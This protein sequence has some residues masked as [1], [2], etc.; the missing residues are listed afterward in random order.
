MEKRSLMIHQQKAVTYLQENRK[1]GY[2]GALFMEMRL[3]KTLTMI[4]FLESE[5]EFKKAPI[6]IL[7]PNSVK[8]T[9]GFELEEEG[10]IDY[11][12]VQGTRKQKEEDLQYEYRYVI[13]NY[14]SAERLEL[15]LYTWGAIVADES[16]YMANPKANISKYLLRNFSLTSYRYILCGNPAPESALQYFN[17][18]MFYYGSFM[19]CNNYWSYREHYFN[20]DYSGYK[21]YIKP[22][23]KTKIYKE[24]RREAFTLTRE[25]AGVGS[26]KFYQKLKVPT[27]KKQMK[28]YYQMKENFEADGIS[29]KYAPVK[30]MFM[31]KIAGGS[32]LKMDSWHSREK[33]KLLLE[34]VKFEYPNQKI[35]V[36]FKYLH[37]IREVSRYLTY[38]DVPALTIFGEDPIEERKR[39]REIFFKDPSLQICCMTIKSMRTGIDMSIADTAIYY[40]NEF[41]WD[42]R[43]QSEDRIISPKQKKPKMFID[44][45]SDKTVDFDIVDLLRGKKINSR[46]FMSALYEKILERK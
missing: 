19:S 36:W 18:M 31:H 17:Q 8:Y 16:I 14:E 3:G 42:L 29:T 35:L 45:C 44:L 30:V 10:I 40:S 27:T 41:S 26:K 11:L 25:E 9:W 39:K 21:W 1:K 6:L 12:V 7:C 37:E 34:L 13:C 2:G 15:H 43:S 4:R 20:K 22:K 33:M 5:P 28:A 24:I 32:N 38:H 23:L 46:F